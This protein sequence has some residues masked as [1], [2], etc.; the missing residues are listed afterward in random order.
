MPKVD[1]DYCAA[2]G[3]DDGPL[4]AGEPVDSMVFFLNEELTP[5]TQVMQCPKCGYVWL[6]PKIDT[7]ELNKY[8]SAQ[9]R[10]P[11]ESIAYK[12]QMSFLER[13]LKWP[14][15]KSAL[16]VGAFDGRLLNLIAQKG[17]PKTFAVEPDTEHTGEGFRTLEDAQHHLG[18]DSCSLITM[19][20]VFEHVQDPVKVLEQC[21]F[22]LHPAG[23]LFIEVPDLADPQVQVVPF[24]TP[25]HQSYFT[26]DTLTYMLERAGFKIL[27]IE[28]TGYRAIRIL[29][30][31][32]QLKEANLGDTPPPHQAM[33]GVEIYHRNRA[34][35][36][37]DMRERLSWLEYENIAIF[38]AGD[39]TKWLLRFFPDLKKNLVCF[40]D[41]SPAKQALGF[42][43]FDVLAPEDCP[44]DVD[45]IIISSYDTQ[46]EMAAIV[47]KRAMQ[48][49][50][51]VRAY[52]VWLGA[53]NA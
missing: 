2:C 17:V 33:G 24:W 34:K 22:L 53:D 18:E 20:H 47:G 42:Y 31:Y 7:E 4:V 41:S 25:F 39:H 28:F 46:D 32:F 43:G 9:D 36:I 16:D 30:R 40:L 11:T 52:D 45:R 44:K 50:E 23:N 8:Y 3:S 49:Y 37:E 38:G 51:D 6:Y 10:F 48:L 29:A 26:S 5:V 27:G 1:T 21:K 14:Q 12:E 19:G 13:F 15:V 35:L